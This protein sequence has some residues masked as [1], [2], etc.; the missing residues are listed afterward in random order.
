VIEKN[1]IDIREN[2]KV[3]EIVSE[4]GSFKV[5]TLSGDQ[6]DTKYVLL[7]IGR[8][9]T[10][11]KLGVPGEITEKVAYRLLEPEEIKGKEI[12]VVGGGDSAIESALLLTDQNNV[13]ISY[14][15]E[16][17]NRLKPKNNQ[18]I[19]EAI[20]EGKIDVRFKTNL[21]AIGQDEVTLSSEDDGTEIKIKNDLVYIFA[22]GELPTQFLEKVGIKITKKF[23]E[24][25]LKH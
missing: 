13:I 19:N 10:P 21:V 6:Y 5:N 7:T 4:N 15:N 18:K 20:A 14:R 12:M 25:I 1:N 17:F 9:G 3:E 8:R 23:G 16:G 11:R 24:A 22:G 2:S